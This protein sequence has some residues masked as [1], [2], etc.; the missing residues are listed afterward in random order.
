MRARSFRL[1][2]ALLSTLVSGSILLAFGWFF[3]GLIYRVGL[4][5]IDREIRA[6]GESQLRGRPRRDVG[7]DFERSLHFIYGEG[8]QRFVL[9]LLDQ[10]GEVLYQSPR[11]PAALDD[12]SLPHLGEILPEPEPGRRPPPPPP[13]GPPPPFGHPPPPPLDRPPGAPPEEGAPRPPRPRKPAFATIRDGATSWRVGVM[14]HERNSIV[15]GVDLAA[16][17]ADNDRYRN[18]FLVTC[19][20]AL[21]LLAGGGWWLATRALRPVGV[22]TGTAAR[23]NARGLNER[24]PAIRSDRELAQLVEVMNRM[25]ERLERS[26]R[27]AARFSADAAHELKTPLTILQ[28]QLE[29]VLQEAPDGSAEQRNY[30]DLLAEVQRLRSIIRKLLLLAQADAG[31]MRG[32]MD[33][34]HLSEK[35]QEVLE[36]IRELAPHLSVRADIAPDVWVRG[37]PDLLTQVLQN[38][39]SNAVKFN[40]GNPGA[41]EIELRRE[42]GHAVFR[43]ANTGQPLS[44]E[45]QERIFERFY[46]GDP[47]RSRRVEGVGLGLSL[48]REI[49]TSHGGELRVDTA[50]PGW[51]RFT[52]VLPI[53]PER[54]PG[55]SRQPTR[56]RPIPGDGPD[57]ESL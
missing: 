12:R 30:G 47:S 8:E 4:E 29:Q 44:R 17:L 11:W 1:K 32:G 48:A 49:A 16:F 2:I 33:A 7:R 9:R 31:Q 38:L 35:A 20:L 40:H 3:L 57:P 25:L 56:A 52:L 37:D 26:F 18:L 54:R 55:D 36:D 41:I 10:D 28:G 24:I 51:V 27:Q 43:M 23:I 42:D 39:A 46:R 50:R 22:I 45:E 53:N 6:L 19:P 13:P 5:R 34:V 15:L 14:G 21:A